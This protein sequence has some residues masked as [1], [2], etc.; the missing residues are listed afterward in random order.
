[1][2]QDK[3]KKVFFKKNQIWDSAGYATF[4]RRFSQPFTIQ[5]API[6]DLA[7]NLV[8]QKKSTEITIIAKLLLIG[9]ICKNKG[10]SKIANE[11]K[12]S[13]T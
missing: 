11:N 3:Q 8:Q 7:S 13:R 2:L 5:K 4:T 12:S 6:A 10:W 1:M 9:K